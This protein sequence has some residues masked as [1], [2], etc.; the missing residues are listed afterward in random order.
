MF[1]VF[2]LKVKIGAVSRRLHFR[3]LGFPA[4]FARLI[5]SAKLIASAFFAPIVQSYP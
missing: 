4:S 3:A 5:A 1:L 2:I